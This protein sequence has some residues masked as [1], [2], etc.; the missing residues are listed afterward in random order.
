MPD[1]PVTRALSLAF[2]LGLLGSSFYAVVIRGQSL[3]HKL[4]VPQI[5]GVLAVIAVLWL[6]L[7]PIFAAA[8]RHRAA[9]AAEPKPEQP[10]RPIAQMTPQELAD[11]ARDDPS[12]LR[13]LLRY[14][15][16]VR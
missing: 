13:R 12:K 11:W 14:Y 1:K 2:V 5:L 6:I 9:L 7:W 16:S 15:R 3:F 8:A 10:P 4:T